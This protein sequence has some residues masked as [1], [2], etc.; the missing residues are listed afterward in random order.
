MKRTISLILT[1]AMV[2]VLAV[3]CFAAGE[4]DKKEEE[5]RSVTGVTYDTTSGTVYDYAG[6][7]FK[8]SGSVS[9]SAYS[10]YVQTDFELLN[11]GGG[12]TSSLNDT[13]QLPGVSS[14]LVIFTDGTTSN[15]YSLN[16]NKS[17]SSSILGKYTRN[18]PF[19]GRI[20]SVSCTHSLKVRAFDQSEAVMATKIVTG[21]TYTWMS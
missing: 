11:Y 20:D 1:L 19:T 9:I 16:G 4:S 21:S 2:L 17:Y 3:P 14:S 6:N 12:V 7:R 10:A 15:N 13:E 18:Q 8:M 5:A